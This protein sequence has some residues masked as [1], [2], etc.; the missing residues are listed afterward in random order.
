RA[1]RTGSDRPGYRP[2]RRRRDRRI[3]R[4]PRRPGPLPPDP[5]TA[6]ARCGS[7]EVVPARR[8]LERQAVHGHPA[9]L[10][11][12]T[13]HRPILRQPGTG[14]ERGRQSVIVATGEDPRVRVD[15]ERAGRVA[16]LGRY[17]E[18]LAVDVDPAPARGRAVTAV[19]EQTVW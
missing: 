9:A 7:P 12:R 18:R 19:G 5:D 16:H 14:R 2:R 15:T 13:D 17:R 11:Y 1:A 8:A 3:R 4:A 6:V 10:P